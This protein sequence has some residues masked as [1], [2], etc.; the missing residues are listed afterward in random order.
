MGGVSDYSGATVLQ[1]PTSRL[2]TLASVCAGESTGWIT[3]GMECSNVC[4]ILYL[5][6]IRECRCA[7]S[8]AL[9]HF[10]TLDGLHM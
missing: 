5:A 3:F 6:P 4:G 1:C 10:S 7:A 8:S 9:A 2:S